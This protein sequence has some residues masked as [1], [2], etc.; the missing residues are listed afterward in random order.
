[1]ARKTKAKLIMQLRNQG[2]S[3]RAIASAQDMARNSV[4]A[5]IDAAE[6]LGLG[7][8]EVAELPEAEVYPTLF[9]GRNVRESVFAQPDW[10]RVHKELARVG[11][12]LKLLHQEY[13]DA[14]SM[15]Q[16]T[17]S[18]DRFCRL[19]GEHVAVSRATSRVGHKA[20][21]SIEVDWSQASGHREDAA[22]VV[23]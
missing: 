17:M 13:I 23:C 10:T 1:M 7:W 14:T 16:A 15:A 11:V 3:G 19:N 8:D 12:T 4:Q 9:P 2:L 5:V 21:R 20:G 6:K 22:Y 18:Y